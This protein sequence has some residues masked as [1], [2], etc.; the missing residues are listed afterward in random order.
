MKK[1]Y[2]LKFM[3]AFMAVLVSALLVGAAFA[4][5]YEKDPATTFVNPADESRR[6]TQPEIR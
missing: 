2:R 1:T 3:A 5:W 4:V 6:K